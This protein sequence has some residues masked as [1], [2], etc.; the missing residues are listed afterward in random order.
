MLFRSLSPSKAPW[1]AGSA[2][3][4]DDII[5]TSLS[6][7]VYSSSYGWIQSNSELIAKSNP[8]I[9]IIISDEYY[10]TESDYGTMLDNL[11]AEWKQTDAYK[12]NQ[13]YLFGEE[14]A[15]MA[16]IPGPRYAQL[17]EI[18]VLVLYHEIIHPDEI[19]P[20]YIGD[21]YRDFLTITEYLGF[22]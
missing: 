14:L 3:Y 9:A 5:V 13:I 17:M 11:S 1:V 2:T 21:N 20:N 22:E 19:F 12:N 6:E 15:E 16:Q 8:E 10:A 7:N 18:I 4:V